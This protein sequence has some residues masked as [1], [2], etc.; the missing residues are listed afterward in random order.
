MSPPAEM[1][2]NPPCVPESYFVFRHIV[3]SQVQGGFIVVA[4]MPVRAYDLQTRIR[5]EDRQWASQQM[6]FA[7]LP[8]MV[9]FV[10]EYMGC[11]PQELDR[12]ADE[13]VF[14]DVVDLH[15]ARTIDP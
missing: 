14:H 4:R 9:S 8:S 10:D 3:V 2:Q 6:V 7:T 1:I 5:R 13:S 11:T 12:M 15:K